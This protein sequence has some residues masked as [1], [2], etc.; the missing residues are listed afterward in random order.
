MSFWDALAGAAEG[1]GAAWDFKKKSEL[2]ERLEKEREERADQRQIDRE[3]RAEA[4]ELRT[5]ADNMTDYDVERGVKILRNREGAVLGEVPMTA[6]EQDR[7]RTSAEKDRLGIEG[8]ITGNRLSALQLEQAPAEF[9][10]KQ[11]LHRDRLATNAAQR[12]AARARAEAARSGITSEEITPEAPADVISDM[13]DEILSNYNFSS[14]G[15]REGLTAQQMA[16]YRNLARQ[17]VMKARATGQGSLGMARNFFD[18]ELQ[19]EKPLEA[20]Y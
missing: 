15:G 12:E 5:P 6:Y 2:A 10:M 20:P 7:L 13:V 3:A 9:G 17:S 18:I 8:L 11:E 1:F 14:I 16:R 19:H 4:K